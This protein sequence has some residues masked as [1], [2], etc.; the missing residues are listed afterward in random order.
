MK[1][2]YK[3]EDLGDIS[4]T[5]AEEIESKRRTYWLEIMEENYCLSRKLTMLRN[6]GKNDK[7]MKP[8]KNTS[9]ID[10]TPDY[11]HVVY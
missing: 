3:T 9:D 5:T 8:L 11:N 1:K 4:L 7:S 2:E 6:R 10:D